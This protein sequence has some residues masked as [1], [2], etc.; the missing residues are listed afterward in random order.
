LKSLLFNLEHALSKPDDS[1]AGL[2]LGAL[3][4]LSL[5]ARDSELPESALEKAQALGI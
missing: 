5:F 3:K 2:L 1:K 4:I